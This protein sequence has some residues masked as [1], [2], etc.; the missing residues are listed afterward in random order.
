MLV[1]IIAIKKVF[2]SDPNAL[3]SCFDGSKDLQEEILFIEE[4]LKRVEP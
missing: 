4:I 2:R 3:A 1:S